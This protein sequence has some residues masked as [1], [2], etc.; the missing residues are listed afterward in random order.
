[1]DFSYLWIAIAISIAH[2]EDYKKAKNKRRRDRWAQLT[3]RE[4]NERIRSIPRESLAQPTHAPWEIAYQSKNDRAYITLTGL[5]VEAFER[6]HSLFA[7]VFNSYSPFSSDGR[8]RVL[9][10][11]ERRA[12]E[13]GHS[14]QHRFWPPLHLFD[15]AFVFTQ[16]PWPWGPRG[17]GSRA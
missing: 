1:M 9:D 6:L 13:C 10:P 17:P 5:N 3:E 16:F 8:I 14:A 15:P 12:A 7:P 4:K 11:E 2:D